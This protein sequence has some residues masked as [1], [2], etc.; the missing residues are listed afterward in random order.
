MPDQRLPTHIEVS[1]LIRAVQ[2]AGG[3]ATVLSKGERD[4]GTIMVI[5]CENGTNASAWERMPQRDGTR[6]FECARTED[7]ENKADF[8]DFWRRRAQQDPDLW[9][10]ELDVENATRFV[11]G[12][13]TVS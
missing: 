7:P 10:V 12:D 11:A 6:A 1:G 5:C 8:F 4:A 3:F 13:G 9:V 2:A